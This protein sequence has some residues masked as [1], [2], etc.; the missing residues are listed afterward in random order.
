MLFLL[1][2]TLTSKL[3]KMT[4]KRKKQL[5]GGKEPYLP[6]C[7]LPIKGAPF[8]S[9]EEDN[10]TKM[11]V[12][13]WLNWNIPILPLAFLTFANKSRCSLLWNLWSCTT[14][15][16]SP[17]AHGSRPLP[18]AWVYW[19]KY[20]QYTWRST[21]HITLTQPKQVWFS[22]CKKPLEAW[23]FLYLTGASL[24]PYLRARRP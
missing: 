11:A 16:Y 24:S 20:M 18:M 4:K 12:H 23:N 5:D 9:L 7:N 19:L 8:P 22:S 17:D 1:T 13:M 10:I 21:P 2:L 15:E 3:L 6:Y 14:M